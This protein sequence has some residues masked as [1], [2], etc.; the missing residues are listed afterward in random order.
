M[1]RVSL[2]NDPTSMS[3]MLTIQLER[4]LD[5]NSPT[6]AIHKAIHEGIATLAEDWIERNK[7]KIYERLNVDA[8]AN[9]IMVETAKQIKD[10]IT[11]KEKKDES[12]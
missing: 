11:T 10:D 3:Q 6:S 7:D 2:V 4:D 1:A 8:I 9:M 12:I 5:M